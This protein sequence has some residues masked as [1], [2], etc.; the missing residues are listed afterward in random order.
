[1]SLIMAHEAGKFSMFCFKT[2]DIKNNSFRVPDELQRRML[3]V[4]SQSCGLWFQCRRRNP[5]PGPA[6]AS[7]TCLSTHRPC[8]AVRGVFDAQRSQSVTYS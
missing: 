1:M 8:A 2:N 4:V 5:S 3:A 6:V 7:S